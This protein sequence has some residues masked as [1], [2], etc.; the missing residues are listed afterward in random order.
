LDQHHIRFSLI[1]TN[2]A[3]THPSFFQAADHVGPEFGSDFLR[4]ID[5]VVLLLCQFAYEGTPISRH[6]ESAT[7]GA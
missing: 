1:H 6:R 7:R 2:D 4:S 3:R 5:D